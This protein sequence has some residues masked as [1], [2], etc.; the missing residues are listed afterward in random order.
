MQFETS[1]LSLALL[2]RTGFV[3]QSLEKESDWREQ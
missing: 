1:D 2:Q 3:A